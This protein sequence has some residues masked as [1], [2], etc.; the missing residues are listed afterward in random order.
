MDDSLKTAFDEMFK[1]ITGRS[2]EE[3]NMLTEEFRNM[4]FDEAVAEQDKRF[5][6]YVELSKIYAPQTRIVREAKVMYE[7]SCNI[8][9]LRR[10]EDWRTDSSSVEDKND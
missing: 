9:M 4:T 3:V 5:K 1:D 10:Y 7:L 8:F 2:A 6:K